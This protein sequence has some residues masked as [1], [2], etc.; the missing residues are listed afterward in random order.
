MAPKGG[1][2]ACVSLTL[3]PLEPIVSIIRELK[4]IRLR[5]LEK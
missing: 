4:A 5:A 2:T 1:V 3:R